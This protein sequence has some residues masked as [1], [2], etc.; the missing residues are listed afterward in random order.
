MIKCLVF[1][2]LCFGGCGGSSVD[3]EHPFIETVH[4]KVRVPPPISTATPA[5]ESTTP[6]RR[7]KRDG[8]CVKKCSGFPE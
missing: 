2:S 8:L 5:T 3:L 1:C 4:I 7:E 6:P